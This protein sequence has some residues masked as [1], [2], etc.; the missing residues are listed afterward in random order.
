MGKCMNAPLITIT[1]KIN[2]AL[3]P[4]VP[5]HMLNKEMEFAVKEDATIDYLLNEIVGLS[6]K[7]IPLILVNGIHARP[8]TR[9]N[10]GDRITLWMPMAGG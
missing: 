3:E 6:K 9:L 5:K 8:Q 1:L 10:P 2:H 4:F 7:V